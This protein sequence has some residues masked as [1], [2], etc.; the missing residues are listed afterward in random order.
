MVEASCGETVKLLT[1]GVSVGVPEGSTVLPRLPT[2]TGELSRPAL[3]VLLAELLLGTADVVSVGRAVAPWASLLCDS[4]ELPFD[5][6]REPLAAVAVPEA[7]EIPSVPGF[8]VG[9]AEESPSLTVVERISVG[10]L[11]VLFPEMVEEVMYVDVG[12]TEWKVLL[13]SGNIVRM[14]VV[15]M[16]LV[17]VE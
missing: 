16:I 13:A 3:V 12:A 1:K 11:P 5:E 17:L 4:D 7:R 10:A 14:R 6:G 8:I 9:N 15:V 2:G